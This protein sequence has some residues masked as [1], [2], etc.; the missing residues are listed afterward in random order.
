[1][2]AVAVLDYG[3]PDVLRVV[4][5]PDP[6]AGSGQIRLRVHAAAVNPADT[7]LR[8]GDID[9][10]LAGNLDPPY[11]PGMDAAGIVHEIGPD[12]TTDL[13]VGDRAMAMVVPIDA[14]GGA[15]AEY[16]VLQADQVAPAP[17]G[18]SHVEAATLPMNGLTALLAVDTLDLDPGAWLAVTGAVGAVGGYVVELAKARGIRVIADASPADEALV[19]KLGADLIVARG[20]GFGDRVHAALPDGA[21]AVADTALL[22]EDVSAAL[23]PGGQIAVFRRPGERGTRP[24][25][26]PTDVSV[27]DIWVPEYRLARHKLDYLRG[28]VEQGKITLRVADV[29]PAADAPAAHRRLEAGG[30]RGRLVLDIWAPQET[31]EPGQ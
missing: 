21:A 14:S 4:D 7:L 29:Y 30:V 31:Q 6:R 8:V 16:V 25:G 12:T 13:Q 22:G 20:P 10:A 1:M 15:Y 5:V 24:Y 17:Q 11:R 18:T 3:G 26:A 28:L 23:R 27:R 19:R 9:A 2:K